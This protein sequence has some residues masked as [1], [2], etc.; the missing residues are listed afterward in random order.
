MR[1]MRSRQDEKV[2]QRVHVPRLGI[3]LSRTE[4]SWPLSA[5]RVLIALVL[6]VLT[7]ASAPYARRSMEPQRLLEDAGWGL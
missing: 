2:P 4:L 1:L 7:Q 5:K 3:H 6:Q